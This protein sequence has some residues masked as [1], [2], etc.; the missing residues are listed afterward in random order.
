VI[1]TRRFDT[2]GI[3][4]VPRNTH[5][6]VVPITVP[7][8]LTF[9]GAM[10]LQYSRGWH[11]LLA[12]IFLA[13]LAIYVAYGV[14]SRHFWRDFLPS[15]E[16]LRP[17]RVIHDLLNHV[18]LRRARGEEARRYNLLQ[19]LAYSSVVFAAFPMQILSGLTMANGVN[20][21]WPWL[22]HLFGGRQSARTVHFI[23]AFALLLFVLIHVFQVFVAG[24]GNHMRS[25]VSGRYR[26]EPEES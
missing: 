12:W 6:G 1:G 18:K 2:S 26:V 20:A 9:P 4:G 17:R 3:L 5:W 23:C 14:F 15:R 24:F 7:M 13:N 10:D 16:Q 21:A 19:K 22:F 8:W 25:M 11:F